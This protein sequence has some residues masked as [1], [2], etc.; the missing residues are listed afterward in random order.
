MPA[1]VDEALLLAALNAAMQA[2]TYRR[3]EIIVS[4]P[5]GAPA[6]AEEP[7]AEERDIEGQE[8]SEES[9]Q[10][11]TPNQQKQRRAARQRKTRKPNRRHH[12][13]LKVRLQKLPQ[14]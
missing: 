5:A 12:V 2:Q 9:L 1:G 7:V 11:E 10:M 6:G 4:G 3:G 13:G 14:M 8:D